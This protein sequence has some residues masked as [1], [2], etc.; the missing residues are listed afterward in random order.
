MS[1]VRI[2][3]LALTVAQCYHGRECFC[4]TLL[5]RIAQQL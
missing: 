4:E 3:T 5:R 1:P 2:E